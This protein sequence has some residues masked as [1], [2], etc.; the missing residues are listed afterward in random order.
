MLLPRNTFY[1][2]VPRPDQNTIW[3][4][5]LC[6]ID[7]PCSRPSHDPHPDACPLISK[8]VSFDL[9]IKTEL[10]LNSLTWRSESGDYV[11]QE[12]S[13][14]HSTLTSFVALQHL[15]REDKADVRIHCVLSNAE[16]HGSSIPQT[17]FLPAVKLKVCSLIKTK[18]KLRN[19]M[20][21][22]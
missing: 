6:R 18:T 12:K 7:V 22:S 2:H 21:S 10:V 14:T 11:A 19:L 3:A 17:M 1:C 4:V 5:D 9:F 20:I 15:K 8:T 16:V 13:D